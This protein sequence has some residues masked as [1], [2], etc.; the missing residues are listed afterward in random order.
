MFVHAFCGWIQH[1]DAILASIT[2]MQMTQK[3]KKL[4]WRTGPKSFQRQNCLFSIFVGLLPAVKRLDKIFFIAYSI[5]VKK[6][7]L[8]F[9]RTKSK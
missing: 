5:S 4:L 7:K 8:K 2:C 3:H 9:Q 6:E 1:A